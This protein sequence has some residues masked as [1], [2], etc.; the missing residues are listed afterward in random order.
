MLLPGAVV[1]AA[2]GQPPTREEVVRAMRKAVEFYR[3]QV[4]TEGAYH[5]TYTEDLSYGRSESTEGRNRVEV[6]REG[7]PVVGMA[8]LAAY[9]AT[10][11]RYFLDAARQ[12]AYALV[13]GQHCSGGWDYYIEFDPQK[14]KEF[15]YRVDGDCGAGGSRYVTNM[16]DNTTQAATR[17]LMRIDR[18]LG[19][20]DARIHEAARYALDSLVKAQ[21]PN[22][23]WPQRYSRFP[24]PKE[25]PV[26]RASYP[27]TWPR[28]WPGPDYQGH[29]TFNDN[30]IVDDIDTM[31]EAA[32]IYKEPAYLAS[33]E[34]GGDFILL[35]QMPEPQPGWSQQYDRDMHPA[36]ARIF[37]PPS[38]TGG[39]SQG[40]MKMLLVLY[41]ETG[42]KKY[43]D[44]LRRALD[45][46]RRS[47]LPPVEN[48][49]EIRRRVCTPGT[50]YCLARFYELQT[51]RPLYITKGTRIRVKGR[52]GAPIDQVDGYQLSYSD[53]SVLTHYSVLVRGDEI[54]N[55]AREYEQ[56]LKADP[57]SIRRPDKLWGLS[58]WSDKPS[59]TEAGLL[60][61]L[62]KP[63][64]LSLE[65]LAGKAGAILA[66][67]DS[68]GAWVEQGVIGRADRLL[69]VFAAKDMVLTLS[70]SG[71]G[72]NRVGR[73]NQRVIQLKENDTLELFQGGRPPLERIVR[74]VT[75]ARNIET[76]SLYLMLARR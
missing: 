42:K 25:F 30:S 37:E 44:P 65:D 29:Y 53:Q 67:L 21:Y 63:G 20:E 28:Q 7:T 36:W 61:G 27:E 17:L 16:D 23:A 43:L 59:V 15:P 62:A 45:Y 57:A 34:K 40:V 18:A 41:R 56:L 52:P 71:A 72:P 47:A 38:V 1:F 8:F 51:N 11:D 74:S 60:S 2:L 5:F 66:S 54:D 64:S 50:T 32:R 69:W 35:A 70:G 22:G 39:E 24:D 3:T 26:K 73:S 55:L 9:E 13:K 48:P 19:F 33:A 68:R 58:P 49:S 14:R 75:F 10:G 4:G 76:L 6:Q 12:T 31:L 46:Y